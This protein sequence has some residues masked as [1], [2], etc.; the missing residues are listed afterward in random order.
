MAEKFTPVARL[1]EIE[2]GSL[3]C[4]KVGETELALARVDG[5]V[6]VAL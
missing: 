1:D 5:E 6:K 4:V 2:P 3:A